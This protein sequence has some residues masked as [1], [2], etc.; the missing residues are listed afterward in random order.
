[1]SVA[2]PALSLAAPAIDAGAG[3]VHSRAVPSTAQAWFS[4]PLQPASMPSDMFTG[5]GQL[6]ISKTGGDN[7]AVR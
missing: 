5:A 1:M 6:R 3:R 7:A 4:C 2:S